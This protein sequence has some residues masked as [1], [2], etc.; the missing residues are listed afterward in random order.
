MAKLLQAQRSLHYIAV[1]VFFFFNHCASLYGYI[2]KFYFIHLKGL[3]TMRIL[4][5]LPC[6]Y[7]FIVNTMLF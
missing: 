5:F 7:L 2:E 6:L 1:F 4:F 3:K